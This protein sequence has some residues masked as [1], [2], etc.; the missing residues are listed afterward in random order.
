MKT[1]QSVL[2]AALAFLLVGST[3]AFRSTPDYAAARVT[4]VS[5]KHVF[6]LCEPSTRYEVVFE[7]SWMSTD[8]DPGIMAGDAVRKA[9][10]V[11]ERENKPFDAVIISPGTRDVAIKFVE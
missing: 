3:V 7:F 8:T 9:L 10:K 5:G 11:S 6:L 2:I 1:P 4:K